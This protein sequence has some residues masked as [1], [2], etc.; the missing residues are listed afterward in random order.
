VEIRS[1]SLAELHAYATIPARFEVTALLDVVCT[2]EAFTLRER[3]TEPWLKD[4]DAAAGNAPTDWPARFQL[5]DWGLF[6]ARL[7][8]EW[9]GAAAVAP[10]PELVRGARARDAVLWDL[11]VLPERRG[12]GI[13]T[14]LLSVAEAWAAARGRSSMIAETQHINVPACRLYESRDYALEHVDAAAY[15]DLPNE[16]QLVWRRTLV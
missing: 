9:V 13:G 8:G 6:S 4:Y 14:A 10:A 12:R 7:D 2:N 15:P 5:A 3:P 11:R 1:E 16:I